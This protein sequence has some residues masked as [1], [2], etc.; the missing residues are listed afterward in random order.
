MFVQI[1]P[2]QAV[3]RG[4]SCHQAASATLCF[5]LIFSQKHDVEK[6]QRI[7]HRIFKR[8]RMMEPSV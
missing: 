2:S 8:L 4:S 5:M 3:T 7:E 6:Q 1:K